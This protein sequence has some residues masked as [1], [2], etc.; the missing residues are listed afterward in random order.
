MDES[1][2]ERAK[3]TRDNILAVGKQRFGPPEESVKAQLAKVTDREHLQRILL[4]VVTATS[5]QQAV[6]TP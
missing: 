3:A 5:W 2:R 1:D 6:D 4:R